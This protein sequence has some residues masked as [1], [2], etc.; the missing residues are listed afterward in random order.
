MSKTLSSFIIANILILAIGVAGTV[1][2][3]ARHDAWLKTMH[4]DHA[5]FVAW[6]TRT[7]SF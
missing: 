5:E 1:I 4:T 2:Y 3:N 6:Q 7:N